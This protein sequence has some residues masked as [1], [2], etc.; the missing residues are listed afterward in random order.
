MEMYKTKDIYEASALLAYN[1][2]L[3]RLE[4]EHNFY[5]FIF[6]NN[7]VSRKTADRYWRGDL[8]V[9]AEQYADA[10]RT[11]KDRLFARR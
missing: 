2:K 4:P 7:D 3:V 8:L 9:N 1:L 11:L 10:I 6:E 5:W